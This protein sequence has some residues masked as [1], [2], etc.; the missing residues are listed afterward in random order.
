MKDHLY[1]YGSDR[2]AILALIDENP[3]WGKKLSEKYDYTV[4]EVIWAVREEMARG[5]EDVLA[6]RVR[7]LFIDAREAIKAAP[8]VAEVMANELRKDQDWMTEEVM[9]FTKLAEHYIV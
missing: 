9:R 8:L 6:R 3:A 2:E 5:V 7:L 1:V 4:A